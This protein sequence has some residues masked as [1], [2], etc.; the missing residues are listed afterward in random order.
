MNAMTKHG[1]IVFTVVYRVFII[2][3]YSD[4]GGVILAY[5]NQWKDAQNE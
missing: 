5:L 2:A 1:L 3:T 4:K